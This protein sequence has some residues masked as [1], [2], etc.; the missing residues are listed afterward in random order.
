V[1]S[2]DDKKCSEIAD[3]AQKWSDEAYAQVTHEFLQDDIF[4]NLSVLASDI[5]V[6]IKERSKNFKYKIFI[7]QDTNHKDTQAIALTTVQKQPSDDLEIAYLVTNPKNV[8]AEPN[9]SKTHSVKGAGSAVIYH[10][11]STLPQHCLRIV[12][13]SKPLAMPFYKKLGFEQEDPLKGVHMCLTKEK[14]QKVMN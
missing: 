10:L 11:A 7:C 6:H 12:L 14:I 13:F 8:R 9:T 5:N 1:F 2:D 4:G 3:I